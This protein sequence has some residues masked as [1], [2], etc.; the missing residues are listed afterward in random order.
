M[1]TGFYLMGRSEMDKMGAQ[2]RTPILRG[3]W[4]RTGV[5]GGG[6]LRLSPADPDPLRFGVL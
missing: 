3:W 5:Q 4:Y 1:R 2:E 6:L